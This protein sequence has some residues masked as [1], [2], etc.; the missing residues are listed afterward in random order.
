[1]IQEQT[2]SDARIKAMLEAFGGPATPLSPAARPRRR[3]T[4]RTALLVVAGLVLLGLAVPG[5]LGL[6]GRWETPKQF[7]ADRGR[8]AYV[9]EWVRWTLRGY[10]CVNCGQKPLRLTAITGLIARTPDGP[11]RVYGLRLSRGYTGF[12]W[13]MP[14]LHWVS[15]A[16]PLPPGLAPEQA[17]RR[18]WALQR[19]WA[20]ASDP[21][22]PGGTDPRDP[23]W[24]GLGPTARGKGFGYILGRA[25]DRV[26]S[27]HVLYEDGGTTRGV[28]GNGY[29]LAWMKPG[30]TL[31]NV[32][33]IAEDAGGRTIGRLRSAGYGGM[34]WPHTKRH[35]VHACA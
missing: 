22:M 18:G 17:C 6:L 12:V 26:A 34:P 35:N 20:F 3:A 25:S 30:L 4:S 10:N 9:K 31:T 2:V 29:F 28:V 27:V 15:Y 7:F 8:P 33:V 32:T 23:M 14:R 21:S 16:P 19:L 24:R 11:A 13:A 1:M 5:A